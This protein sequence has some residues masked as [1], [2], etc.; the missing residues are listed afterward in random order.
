MSGRIA[1]SSALLSPPSFPAAALI[2][3]CCACS[4]AMFCWSF[5]KFE[6]PVSSYLVNWCVRL[7]MLANLSGS[8]VRSFGYILV[9]LLVFH[10]L[11]IFD[12]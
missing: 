7:K 12:K 1:F 9:L 11:L 3:I 6:N 8:A 10:K 5:S 2:V 4:F